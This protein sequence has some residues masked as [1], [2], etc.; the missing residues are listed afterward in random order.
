M[1]LQVSHL[2]CFFARC[3]CLIQ[4]KKRLVRHTC[5]RNFPQ[6]GPMT[7]QGRTDPGPGWAILL[8]RRTNTH[9]WPDHRLLYLE[10]ANT[11]RLVVTSLAPERA[12][13]RRGNVRVSG[14]ARRAVAVVSVSPPWWYGTSNRYLIPETRRVFTLLEYG[15]GLISIYVDFLMGDNLYPAGTRVYP[16][17]TGIGS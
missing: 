1:K 6:M 5:P 8:L 3:P 16:V 4:K 12:A 11:D 14:V 2:P 10:N 17:V 13:W 7:S 9:S 15:Y